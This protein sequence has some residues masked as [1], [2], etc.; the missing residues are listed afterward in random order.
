MPENE[1]DFIVRFDRLTDLARQEAIVAELER[2]AYQIERN[3][4]GRILFQ[5][6]TIKLSHIIRDNSLILIQ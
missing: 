6:L 2:A 1:V 5:A 3:A 4:N